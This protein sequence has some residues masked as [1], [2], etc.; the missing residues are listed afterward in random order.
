[1]GAR[2]EG[3]G[4]LADGRHVAMLGT[5]MCWGSPKIAYL[6]ALPLMS[7]NQRIRRLVA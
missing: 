1:M 6:D 5:S 3:P 4:V 7:V 2:A